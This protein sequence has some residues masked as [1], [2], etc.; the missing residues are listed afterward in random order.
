MGLLDTWGTQRYN[1]RNITCLRNSKEASMATLEFGN[2]KMERNRDGGWDGEGGHVIE[3]TLKNFRLFTCNVVTKARGEFLV[4]WCGSCSENLGGQGKVQEHSARLLALSR[5]RSGQMQHMVGSASRQH[6]PTDPV[7]HVR[8]RQMSRMPP[9]V[10]AFDR[11][12]TQP[13]EA[14]KGLGSVFREVLLQL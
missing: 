10:T 6:L 2:K 13:W 4:E 11:D 3:T 9:R 8:E 14:G 5:A 1:G 7:R 12:A